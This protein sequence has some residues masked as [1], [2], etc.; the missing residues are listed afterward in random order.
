[1]ASSGD[2]SVGIPIADR[3]NIAICT[4]EKLDKI[5]LSAVCSNNNGQL[6]Y[7]YLILLSILRID[8]GKRDIEWFYVPF[9]VTKIRSR[10][11]VLARF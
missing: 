3:A 8:R 1:M 11:I 9:F 7:L 5:E 10:W 6:A 2:C 4:F